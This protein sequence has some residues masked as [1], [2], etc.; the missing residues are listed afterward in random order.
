M[1]YRKLTLTLTFV[2]GVLAA[3]LAG[4]Q[5]PVI[6]KI[7]VLSVSPAPQGTTA[8][9]SLQGFQHELRDH[10]WIEGQNL[11]VAYRWAAGKAEIVPD[12]A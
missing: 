11:T 1:S 8:Y 9:P 10:G 4:A 2:L 7:G 12:L 5:P 6:R 3:P